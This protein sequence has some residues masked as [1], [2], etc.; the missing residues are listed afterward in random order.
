MLNI[1]S[2]ASSSVNKARNKPLENMD[3]ERKRHSQ[4]VLNR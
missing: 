2:F 1:A 3:L 4:L